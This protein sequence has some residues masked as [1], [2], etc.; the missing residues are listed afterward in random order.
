[1]ASSATTPNVELFLGTGWEECDTFV[2]NIRAAAW[3]EDKLDDDRW[4]ANY[5]SLHLAGKALRW[6]S[7]LPPD[8][9]RDWSK[10]EVALL[11]QWPSPD[12]T[13]DENSIQVPIVPTPAA[14]PAN[15]NSNSNTMS[16]ASH[17]GVVKIISLK[18]NAIFYLGQPDSDGVCTLT[19]EIG[20]ALPVSVDPNANPHNLEMLPN[21]GKPRH[22]YSWV[23]I[24]WYTPAPLIRS[25]S[26]S[27]ARIALVD[28]ITMKS[29]WSEKSHEALITTW[30]ISVGGD[31]R[32]AW[33]QGDQKTL[34][35][36]FVDEESSNITIAADFG[37]YTTTY[38]TDSESRAR[39]V[40]Q[41]LT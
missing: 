28:S 5:A 20:D 25:G 22:R 39:L 7:R 23:G 11:D 13:D 15:S 17:R 35:D 14:A 8:V 27:W 9:R 32:A 34:L 41:P 16:R 26:A 3:K 21:H 31:I 40:L 37:G 1:M 36:A 2:R 30:D 10:L 38:P 29:S 19:R 24:H 4:I 6:H 12:N 18:S 33:F